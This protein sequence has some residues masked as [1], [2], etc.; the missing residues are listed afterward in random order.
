VGSLLGAAVEALTQVPARIA[1]MEQLMPKTQVAFSYPHVS[2]PV[3]TEVFTPK[4]SGTDFETRPSAWDGFI[5]SN[6]RFYIRSHSPTPDIDMAGWRLKIDGSGVNTPVELTYEELEAM[7]QVTLTRTMECAGNGRRFYKEHFGVEG[8][9]G[10]WRMGAM[11]CAEWTGICLRDVLARAGVKASARD[12]MPI[13]LDD[14]EVCRPMP[15]EKAMRED[16]LLVL[17]M[18]GE[19]LP[20][21][22]GFPVRVLVTGWTGTASIKWAGRIEVAEEPLYSPYNTMEYIMVGPDYPM[23]FPALGPAITEMP[24]MSVLDLDWPG[25][26]SSEVKTIHGRSFAGEGKLREVVYSIDDGEWKP[27]ELT[28]PDIEGCWR[29]WEFDWHP[30]PGKHEIR[31]RATDDRGRTQPDSVPWNHHGYLYNAVVAHPVTVS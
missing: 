19:T 14:H 29:Q 18:N 16:T 22:H 25:E 9:G 26:I 13:G 21:D 1:Q 28:G 24:V 27:A 10:Q 2:K 30:S 23:Q 17:K 6:D 12:V 5:T 3:P 7:P 8:E 20:V 31:V 15:L 4:G 11:G